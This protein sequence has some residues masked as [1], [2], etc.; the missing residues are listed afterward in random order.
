MDCKGLLVKFKNGLS[1]CEA[2]TCLL[3]LGELTA[4]V[5]IHK[6]NYNYINIFSDESL[7]KSVVKRHCFYIR[8]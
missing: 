7:D 1:N 5:N 3:Q 8:R 2:T 4:V 6:Y